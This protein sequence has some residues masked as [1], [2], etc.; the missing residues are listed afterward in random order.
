MSNPTFILA[1]MYVYL[2]S[3]EYLMEFG[4]LCVNEKNE[5]EGQ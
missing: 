4:T 2:K 1:S 3:T 5:G